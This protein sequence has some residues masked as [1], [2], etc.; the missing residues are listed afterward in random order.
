MLFPFPIL[1]Y[2]YLTMPLN[3]TNPVLFT[4]INMQFKSTAFPHAGIISTGLCPAAFPDPGKGSLAFYF[5]Y[6]LSG[7]IP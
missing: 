6:P 4:G 3:A 7:A 5:D 2:Y 1:T